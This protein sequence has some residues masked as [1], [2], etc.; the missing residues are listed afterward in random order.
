MKNHTQDEVLNDFT[1]RVESIKKQLS[2]DVSDAWLRACKEIFYVAADQKKLDLTID[3]LNSFFTSKPYR[4]NNPGKLVDPE[5]FINRVEKIFGEI[6]PEKIASSLKGEIHCN[7]EKGKDLLNKAKEEIIAEKG[8]AKQR[9]LANFSDKSKCKDLLREFVN[10][11]AVS[12]NPFWQP[13]IVGLETNLTSA[14]DNPESQG[15]QRKLRPL[16]I[17]NDKAIQYFFTKSPNETIFFQNTLHPVVDYNMERSFGTLAKSSPTLAKEDVFTLDMRK[18]GDEGTRSEFA[19]SLTADFS[20]L[21]DYVVLFD[22][23]N[24]LRN[25]GYTL[26]ARMVHKIGDSILPALKSCELYADNPEIKRDLTELISNGLLATRSL[27]AQGDGAIYTIEQKLLDG[28]A[29]QVVAYGKCYDNIHHIYQQ[30]DVVINEM[31][32]IFKAGISIKNGVVGS[33]ELKDVRAAY[34][35]SPGNNAKKVVYLAEI[36]DLLR[37]DLTVDKL[38]KKERSVLGKLSSS[39]K[40]LGSADKVLI[41]RVKESFSTKLMA[42]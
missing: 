39:D 10:N 4:E 5:G 3:D 8:V 31:E 14:K 32:K 1:K 24:G 35:E 6:D 13:N 37:D 22:S 29:A 11:R 23:F 15:L 17:V 16:V 34:L 21:D 20:R 12:K 28:I 30:K 25:N 19:L 26:N 18:L 2:K 38:F 40:S 27:T 36:Y 9:F 41:E 42:H 33:Q 7:T